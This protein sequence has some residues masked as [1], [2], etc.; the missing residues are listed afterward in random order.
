MPRLLLAISHVFM[1][2]GGQN[3]V[4]SHYKRGIRSKEEARKI[5]SGCYNPK[6]KMPKGFWVEQVGILALGLLLGWFVAENHT[7]GG[8]EAS[9][10]L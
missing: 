1:A 8:A 4:I 5:P 10:L 6:S 7:N 9:N 2:F 3:F